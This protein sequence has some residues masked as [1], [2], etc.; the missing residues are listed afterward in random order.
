MSHLELGMIPFEYRSFNAIQFRPVE[1][2]TPGV[3][4]VAVVDPS[5][6]AWACMQI[7]KLFTSAAKRN[8]ATTPQQIKHLD[9]YRYRIKLLHVHLLMDS[10]VSTR[11]QDSQCRCDRTMHLLKLE[12]T[13]MFIRYYQPSLVALTQVIDPHARVVGVA[14]EQTRDSD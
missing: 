3:L 2:D 8:P 11:E 14:V 13:T 6:F 7:M 4:L 9:E 10:H 5:M 1:G 12:M